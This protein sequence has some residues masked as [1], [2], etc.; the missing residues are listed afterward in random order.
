MDDTCNCELNP[1]Q[2]TLSSPCNKEVY[3][4]G[5]RELRSQGFHYV[6]V[7]ATNG[8]KLEQ[9]DLEIDW[10]INIIFSYFSLLGLPLFRK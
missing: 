8:Q 3:W 10:E 4:G 9:V 2:G 1:T 6:F 5:G 7:S